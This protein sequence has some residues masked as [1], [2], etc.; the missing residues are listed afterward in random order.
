MT[1]ICRLQLNFTLR[2]L[3]THRNV[4]VENETFDIENSRFFSE[5]NSTLFIDALQRNKVFDAEF[6]NGLISS[7]ILP[8]LVTESL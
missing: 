3:A 2:L 5:P 4:P 1:N 6:S 8:A 7:K